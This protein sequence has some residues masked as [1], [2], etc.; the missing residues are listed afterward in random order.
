[1]EQKECESIGSGTHFM[2]LK[3]DLSHTLTLNFQ[4]QNLKKV[5]FQEW[6]G[7]LTWN[8]RDASQ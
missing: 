8:K 5:V 2:A 1:M 4:G 7:P 3:C 6:E